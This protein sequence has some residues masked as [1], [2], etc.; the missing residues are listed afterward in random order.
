HHTGTGRYGWLTMRPMSLWESGESTGEVSL[1]D[2]FL[3]PDRIGA[4][5][6]EIIILE[7]EDT[8]GLLCVL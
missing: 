1:S 8:D 6:K 2:L 3:T 5:M 7:L 4:D